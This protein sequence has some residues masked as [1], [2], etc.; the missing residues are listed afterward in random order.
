M[1]ARFFT[2][3]IAIAFALQT[4]NA[5]THIV[6]AG[7]EQNRQQLAFELYGTSIM[8]P[9][10]VNGSEPVWFIFDTGAE[11]TLI[12]EDRLA[13]IGTKLPKA[14]KVKDV[15]LQIA[16]IELPKQT[17]YVVSLSRLEGRFGRPISGVIGHALLAHSIVGIDYANRVMSVSDP[18]N[19]KYSGRGELIPIRLREGLPYVRATI[20]VEGIAPLEAEFVIDTGASNA[21]ALNSPFVRTN[22]LIEFAGPTIPS[23]GFDVEVGESKQLIGRVKTL[24][25]GQFLVDH[26][27]TAFSQ[28]T[29]GDYADAGFAGEIGGEILRRFNVI[30]DYTHGAV[31]LEPNSSFGQPY[32]FNMSGAFIREEGADFKTFKVYRVLES[33]PATEAGIH[34]GDT[35]TAIDGR[36]ASEMNSSQ[37]QQMFK[38]ASREYSLTI[39]RGA[40]VLQ[41]RIKLRRLV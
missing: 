11:P 17:V 41:I 30:L 24:R 38:Q 32:E 14:E 28:A 37:I 10:R 3:L 39:T 29:K 8:L 5:R 20:T 13:S 31:I 2:V 36:P 22:K 21:L 19:Y 40:E 26:P 23:Y 27:I 15:S 1:I 34:E 25:L 4:S 9:V 12:N 6:P 7:D 35:L 16:G 33:S 18:V